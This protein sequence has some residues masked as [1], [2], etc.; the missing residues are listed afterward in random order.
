M[1]VED[2]KEQQIIE[3]DLDLNVAASSSVV[4]EPEFS[5]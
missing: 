1:I 3:E 5:P 2:E 4:E